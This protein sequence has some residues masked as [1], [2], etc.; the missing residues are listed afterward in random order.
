MSLILK[1]VRNGGGYSEQAVICYI[2]R[3]DI[4]KALLNVVLKTPKINQSHY[5][6]RLTKDFSEQ[7]G[8]YHT[9]YFSLNNHSMSYLKY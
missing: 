6:L 7:K 4:A 1:Q 8:V 3:H 2:G 5:L 9:Q